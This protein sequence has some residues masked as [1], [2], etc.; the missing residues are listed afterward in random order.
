[1][2]C[3]TSDYIW[4]INQYDKK[5]YIIDT[6]LPPV[7]AFRKATQFDLVYPEALSSYPVSA[8]ELN[9]FQAYGDWIGYRWIN[10][11]MVP[12]A[13]VRPLSG[14]SNIFSIYPDT[15]V[16]NVAKLNEDWDASSYYKSLRYQEILL[17][18]DI[19]F[20]NF[21]GGIVGDLKAQ[22]YEL[23]K[24]VYEKI[25]N[26]VDNKANITTCNLES[27]IS[28]CRELSIPFEEYNYPFPPQLKRLINIL[29]IKQKYLWGE[30]NTFTENF[31]RKGFYPPIEE[32]GLNLG[33]E[34]SVTS[35]F[36][37]CGVPVVA[38]ETFSEIYK[39]VNFSKIPDAEFGTLLP[40]STYKYDWG[41]GLVVPK[42]LKG[43][44][45][46]E[47]YKFYEFVPQFENTFYNNIINWN[48]PKTT[49]SPY[50]SSYSNWSND[51]GIVQT[52]LSY[53]LTKGLRLFTSAANIVYNN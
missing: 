24:T 51:N 45:I 37:E 36:I 27:L 18:K 6:Y 44:E 10:K 53:E 21:L 32:Y 12:Y 17:D 50:N 30:K 35:D 1:M 34:L 48:D 3:D 15:G 52:L 26:F 20:N 8:Y 46:K 28:F 22:P 40:L 42:S 23:G 29:S 14:I 16:N 13:V 9:Q 4:C 5:L 19:F 41:W 49:L 31:N 38:F 39:F 33:R 7:S 43:V 2:T 11:Y 47:Y 25:A